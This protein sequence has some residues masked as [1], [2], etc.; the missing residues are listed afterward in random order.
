MRLLD[1]WVALWLV[2]IHFSLIPKPLYQTEPLY[3]Y[4]G[5]YPRLTE[6]LQSTI[7]SFLVKQG[8]LLTA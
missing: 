1:V 4:T 5:V 2:D 7:G 3:L 8:G 6:I